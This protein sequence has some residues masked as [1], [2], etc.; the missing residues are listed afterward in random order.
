[1][2]LAI[3]YVL[4]GALRGAGAS[5]ASALVGVVTT[6]VRLPLGYLLAIL[7]LNRACQ[8]AVDAGLYATRELAE[9]AGVGMEHYF[10]M[11]QC[12]GFGMV[13]GLCVL[14]PIYIWGNWRSKG[15]TDQAKAATGRGPR[16]AE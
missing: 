7:P 16:P 15:I 12:F 1:M 3:H 13:L 11:F 2:F 14:L 5:T 6:A 4:G 9:K 8:A 10:G